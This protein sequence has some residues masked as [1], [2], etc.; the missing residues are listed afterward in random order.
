MVRF[1]MVRLNGSYFILRQNLLVTG[2]EIFKRRTFIMS[3]ILRGPRGFNDSEL[4]RVG[5]EI[6][7][8]SESII[9]C[10][11][12][13]YAWGIMIP[14]KG[15]KLPSGYWHCPQGCNVPE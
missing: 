7:D 10:K 14:P 4:A 12:C 15:K 8:L 2:G 13:G 11:E 5:V 9:A 6:V 3:I 1:G